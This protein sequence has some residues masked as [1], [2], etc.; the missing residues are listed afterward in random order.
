M[1]NNIQEIICAEV[2][3]AGRPGNPIVYTHVIYHNKEYTIMK[4][5]DQDS[6]IY[7]IIDKEDFITVKDITW[8]YISNGYVS[9]TAPDNGKRK[10]LYLH[11][12]VMNRLGFPGKGS[13]E[14]IDHKNRNGLDNRKEN[15]RLIT[16]TEQN[17]NQKR[18]E[19]K[20]E[21]PPDTEIKV[22]DL[23]KH[24]WYIK[25]NGNHG[26][27]FGIDLKTEGIK[28]KTTSSKKVSLQDKL[29]SAIEQLGK[30]YELYPYL[31]TGNN[32]KTF[33]MALL[34]HEYEE[35]IKLAD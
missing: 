3:R 10:E 6:Y 13:T 34:A 8:H 16:Q 15:L 33:E 28:W 29:Q 11:N 31:N 17:L 4:I 21:L 19:R 1:E 12:M 5:L 20:I 23:P 9:H 18:K 26:E 32:E 35:I 30:Y 2:Q 27:R 22:E 7:S 24:I 14:S 25:P